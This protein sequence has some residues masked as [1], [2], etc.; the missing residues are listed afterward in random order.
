MA[1]PIAPDYG[2]QFLFPPA[3][4]DWVSKD[5]PVRFIR[6]FVDQQDLAKLG[7]AMPVT[8]EGR[9]PYAPGLLLKIWLYGYHGRIRS[10][11]K[12]EAACRDQLPLVWLSGMIVPDHN[13]LWRFW[14]D[15]KKALRQLFKQSVRLA[16]DAGLVGLVLQ[17][18]DGTKIQAAAS[19]Q[20][21][22][23]KAKMEKL[24][25]V[26]EGELDAAEEQLETEG[27]TAE[28]TAYRLPEKLEDRQRLRETIRAGLKQLEQTGGTH[29]HPQ[30][31]Q[32]RRMK[33]HGQHPFAYN[34]QAVVDQSCGVVVAAEVTDE[35]DDSNQLVG[36]AEQARQ[37][38]AAPGSALTVADGSYGTG[39]QIAEA[40]KQG[41]NVLVNPKDGGF[42]KNNGYSARNFHYD[43]G[44]ATVTCPQHQSLDF[45][46]EACVKGQI[47]KK[48]RCHVADCPA[49]KWCKDSKGRRVIEIWN[50]TAAVQA[51]R[52][53]LT[54]APAQHQ[55]KKRGAIIERHF[56]QIKE[57]DGFRRWTVRG[58]DNV[59]TQWAV[60]NLV[61][62]LRVLY[63]HWKN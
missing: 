50:H 45:G 54:Q 22:W 25:A 2:Q 26:L 43:A 48:Y 5:H 56:G 10:T 44:A 30:E 59:R 36:M 1:Q 12:L 6:E 27:Q 16:L 38:T 62:N 17:A 46:G 37:N 28:A 39:A 53:R 9:P 55:L 60:I 13:S 33:S 15:N 49:A 47:I 23:T 34:A 21:G 18:V 24:L 14:R 4:E 63:R 57:H 35:H 58:L 52:A 8:T 31:P 7:F 32:A 11:R 29:Y 3:L 40:A 41:L 19:A 20:G 61:S 51:M 42:K